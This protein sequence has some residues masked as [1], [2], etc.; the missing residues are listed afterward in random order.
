MTLLSEGSET[1]TSLA[2][3]LEQNRD[4]LVHHKQSAGYMSGICKTSFR[5]RTSRFPKRNS[6]KL[7]DSSSS[8]RSNCLGLR[9][10]SSC[11]S[12]SMLKIRNIFSVT[13]RSRECH[14]VNLITQTKGISQK[15]TGLLSPVH[16][17]SSLSNKVC[18]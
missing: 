16:N 10:S 7:S 5:I 11:I 18:K 6:A 8:S 9:R 17:L 4:L 14:Q 3:P 15:F 12:L 2:K 13:A 1:I